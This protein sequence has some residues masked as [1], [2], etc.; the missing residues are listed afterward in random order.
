MRDR[1][2][3]PFPVIAI[4]I[5]VVASISG[6]SSESQA[7]G[8]ESPKF[9]VPDNQYQSWWLVP[10][11]PCHKVQTVSANCSRGA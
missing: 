1:D 4:L 6:L 11:P 2:F 5:L 9:E 8:R 10:A 3:W 7:E